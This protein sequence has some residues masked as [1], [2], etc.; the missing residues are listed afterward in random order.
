[1]ITTTIHR[2]RHIAF[3]RSKLW[4]AVIINL[5]K[6]GIRGQL[7]CIWGKPLMAKPGGSHRLAL[8]LHESSRTRAKMPRRVVG[9]VI[10]RY[11]TKNLLP[12][13]HHRRCKNRRATSRPPPTIHVRCGHRATFFFRHDHIIVSHQFRPPTVLEYPSSGYFRAISLRRST[14]NIL[15]LKPLNWG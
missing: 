10:G 3:N 12:A 2:W 8:F 13:R 7:H 5:E 4:L 11:R 9:Q 15:L 14:S 6:S 1:M